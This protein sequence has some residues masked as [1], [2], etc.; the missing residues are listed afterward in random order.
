[1]STKPTTT[2]CYFR[3]FNAYPKDDP[4]MIK[5]NDNL[6]QDSLYYEDFTKYHCLEAGDYQAS[7]YLPKE[8]SPLASSKIVLFPHRIY[9]LVLAPHPKALDKLHLYCI[10]DIQ[11][12]VTPP[13]CVV[14]VCHF[15][16]AMPSIDLLQDEE[17]LRF[18]NIPFT[19]V[20]RYIPFDTMPYH[21]KCIDHGYKELLLEFDHTLKPIRFYSFYLIGYNTKSFPLKCV[22]SIDG[23]AYLPTPLV[24]GKK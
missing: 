4:L 17:T 15:A 21:F 10:E 24:D 12:L 1:M 13:D 23:N 8:E 5:L 7:V 11:R 6:Y 3:L 14:R 22:V 9:T 2:T 20:S 16:H 18:K 19:Q